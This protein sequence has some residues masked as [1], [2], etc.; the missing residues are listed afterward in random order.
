MDDWPLNNGDLTDSQWKL[1][2]NSG[3]LADMGPIQ[4]PGHP[5]KLVFL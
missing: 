3:D 5:Q 4:R 2:V 1:P